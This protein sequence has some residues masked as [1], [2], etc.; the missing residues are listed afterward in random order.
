MTE[1]VPIRARSHQAH[2]VHL[3]HRLRCN[4]VE[5]KDIDGLALLD[6]HHV[7]LAVL[8]DNAAAVVVVEETIQPY[9]VVEDVGAVDV[10]DAV[11][12]GASDEEAVLEAW[13]VPLFQGLER[14]EGVGV[15][16]HVAVGTQE[17]SA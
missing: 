10:D 17:W 7:L 4:R 6:R 9:G 15:V 5:R 14:G 12:F 2:P 11:R 13:V 8:R 16:L 1:C 3:D